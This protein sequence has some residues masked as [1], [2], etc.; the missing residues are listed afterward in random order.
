VLKKASFCAIVFG[1]LCAS[2]F[3]QLWPLPSYTT[4]D[5]TVPCSQCADPAT[6]LPTP[7]W[8]DP[9]VRYVGR[10]VSSESTADFQ[11]YYRTA[12]A[13][14]IRFSPDHKRLAVKLGNGVAT[15]DTASFISRLDAHEALLNVGQIPT[16]PATTSGN[17]FGGPLEKFLGF[18]HFFYPEFTNSKWSI[19]LADGQDRLSDF[20]FDDRGIAYMAYLMYGWGM[21]SDTGNTVLMSSWQDKNSFNVWAP[22]TSA[23]WVKDGS[24]YYALALSSI[25]EQITHVFKVAAY[26]SSTELP[27]LQFSIAGLARG[28]GRTAVLLGK[29]TVAIYDNHSLVT[30]GNPLVS[31]TTPGS[32]INAVVFDGTNFWT[33]SNTNTYS[34]ILSRISP[35]A[36]GGYLP[37]VDITTRYGQP[38][39][40]TYGDGFLAAST[41]DNSGASIHLFNISTGTP[42]ETSIDS[43]NSY[44]HSQPGYAPLPLHMALYSANP[45][46]LNGHLYLIVNADGI[47]D[48][49]EIRTADS[50]VIATHGTVG[51]ANPNAPVRAAGDVFYGD[52]VNLTATLSSGASGGA[53]TWNFGG[54]VT[55]PNN[56]APGTFGASVAHQYTGLRTTDVIAPL[57]VKATNSANGV[58]GTLPLILKTGTAR[59]KY[60]SSTGTKY[61]LSA[62]SASGVPIVADDSFYDASDGDTGGHYTEWRFADDPSG[63]AVATP[64]YTT[65]P[66]GVGVGT[67][68]QHTL[69]MTAH[70]GYSS[71]SLTNVDFPATLAPVGGT[72]L[73]TYNVTAF[74]PGVDVSYNGTTGNEEFFS[75]SRAA[76]SLAGRTFSFTWDV[77]DSNGT[78]VTAIAPQT[79]TSISVDQIARYNVSKALFTQPGYK[80]RL[81]LTVSGADP[82]S[83]TGATMPAQQATSNPLVTPDAQI[84]SS[85]VSGICTYTITSPSNVMQ[86][87]AWTFAWTATG[88]SPSSGNASTLITSYYSAGTF[89]VSAVVTNKTGLTK[90]VTTSVNITTTASLCP[91]FSPINT[92]IQ[93]GGTSPST[94][95]TDNSTCAP[96]EQIQFSA[97]FLAPPDANCLSTLQ[98]QWKLDGTAAGT[99]ST[100]VTSFTSAGQHTI[101]LTLKTGVQSVDL[102]R[103]I[104]I[105]GQIIPTPPVTPPNNNPPPSNNGCGTLGATTV[106]INYAGT[107]SPN[108]ALSG[109]CAA[110]ENI[111][112][113]VN[114]YFYNNLCATH[115]YSWSFDGG[116]PVTGE[117]SMSHAFTT[118]GQHTVACTVSN[119][120]SSYT[121]TAGVTVSGGSPQPDPQP[122]PTSCAALVKDQNVFLQYSGAVSHCEAGGANCTAGEQITMIVAYWQYNKDCATHH[123]SWTVDG[124]DLEATT[125]STVLTLTAGTH[126]IAVTV[127]N[128]GAPVTL[129]QTI[130]VGNGATPN[131]TFDFSITQLSL[132]PF[133]YA[134]SVSVTPDA[135][136]P[137]QWLW[138]FGDGTPSFTAGAVQTHTFPDDKEYTVTVTATDGTGAV[139]SHK[140]AAP[141]ARRRGVHH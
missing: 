16:N 72:S 13:G 88:G 96:N 116:A 108:C 14:G 135:N 82:C 60:G 23:Y 117:Q 97:A 11:Q 64:Q 38:Q 84:N 28:N 123:Y 45:L 30:G 24:D 78:P 56:T 85:C 15:Y 43:I 47:G 132:P 21:A 119:G 17:R 93:Y 89:N 104:T 134:F 139:V 114:F 91:T 80:G 2:A 22:A 100:F 46:L 5:T 113:A 101:G 10:F 128:G 110:G 7:G 111:N 103:I 52:T 44:F 3:A 61:L 127:N 81:T 112:F 76:A 90:T 138:N 59:L 129:S 106:F 34:L 124:G 31:Y 42:V 120:T 6:N 39:S 122:Q 50:V 62:G 133:S 102:T 1:F 51:P 40:L 57:T 99:G 27:S 69:S 105:V 140:I 131:Y 25:H 118:S 121:A 136:K 48:V 8:H 83:Q 29:S 130:T 37:K 33:A 18:E 125:D 19:A 55:D 71:P 26:N 79:G 115:T 49:Y 141:P 77:V 68:G 54:A 86:S 36:N 63:I 67:C 41:I 95:C 75:T 92:G 137:T 58:V 35:D 9:V 12:R 20:D 126:T 87:D 109:T 32:T 98:Y 53:L 65:S 94:T 74:V 4:P 107:T 73:V 70:Y 66:A